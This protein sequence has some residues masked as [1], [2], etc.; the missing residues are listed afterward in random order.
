M[1][2]SGKTAV[3]TGAGRGLGRAIAIAYAREGAAVVAAARSA[4]EIAETAWLVEELGQRALPVQVDIRQADQVE[5]LVTQTHATFGAPHILVNSAGIG[6]RMPFQ[7]TSEQMWDAVF[8]TLLKGMYLVTQ[9]FLSYFIE[10]QYGNIINIGA[11][12]DRIAMPGFAAYCSAKYGVEGLTRVLAKEVRRHGINVNLLHPGGF[13]NTRMV[14]ETV[15][16]ATKGLLPTD[17]IAAA[18]VALAAQP[19]RGKTGQIVDAQAWA[20]AA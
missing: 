14:R 11:P 8:A 19:P 18:A 2:L 7:E 9:R 10:Q 5:H 13:A 12:L 6:L 16:E 20:A 15:P 1:R 3:I 4:D 17:S